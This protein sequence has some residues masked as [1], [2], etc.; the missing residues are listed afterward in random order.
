MRLKMP[1]LSRV[2]SFF[3]LSFSFVFIIS[4]SGS[5]FGQQF[6]EPYVG[7]TY[8]SD[9]N[10]FNVADTDEAIAV[11]GDSDKGEEI[12]RLY[13]GVE[14]E[15]PMSRQTLEYGLHVHNNTYDR[16]D[17]LDNTGHEAELNLAWVA[18]KTLSGNLGVTSEE[19][20]ARFWELQQVAKDMRSRQVMFFNANYRFHPEW[21]ING[22]LGVS[23]EDYS[24]RPRLERRTSYT[25]FDVL[26]STSANTRLG[27]G[28]FLAEGAYTNTNTVDDSY[29]AI[30]YS[31]VGRW[32]GTAKSTLL[33]RAGVTERQHDELDERDLTSSSWNLEYKWRI[34]KK[35]KLDFT[36]WQEIKD[37]IEISGFVK[38]TGFSVAPKITFTPK[39]STRLRLRMLTK[40]FEGAA[41]E[42]AR[43]R[44]DDVEV[45]QLIVNYRIT[46]K[47]TTNFR[48]T[49]RE[50]DSNVDSADYSADVWS[51]GAEIR[52]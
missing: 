28:T 38:E 19:E 11:T 9:N 27:F 25:Q 3:T 48:Y 10:F 42:E 44:E 4:F 52:F 6:V 41:V 35:T 39:L 49:M 26:Y 34:T 32:E 22:G 2:N 50:R 21:R 46:P 33:A 12:T 24:E 36:L 23:W 7:V 20:L 15:V 43:D 18:G 40:K 14:G 31:I 45:A 30:N 51:I 5:V 37:D 29:K 17:E 8:S 13:A 1:S 47:I 16:F